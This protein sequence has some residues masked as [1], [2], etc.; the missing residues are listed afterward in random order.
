MERRHMKRNISPHD[1]LLHAHTASPSECMNVPERWEEEEEEEEYRACKLLDICHHNSFWQQLFAKIVHKQHIAQLKFLMLTKPDR[2]EGQQDEG[3]EER[4]GQELSRMGEPFS[5]R[6]VFGTRSVC[7]VSQRL[8][9][10]PAAY[11][12]QNTSRLEEDERI[13]D[14]GIEGCL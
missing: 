10:T 2:K 4:V 14:V 8:Q 11:T 13:V 7:P 1:R 3:R 12:C 9:T 6:D 5:F